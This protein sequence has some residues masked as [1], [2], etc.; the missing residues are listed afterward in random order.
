MKDAP[1]EDYLI[2]MQRLIAD[3]GLSDYN[4]VKIHMGMK[5]KDETYKYISP[6]TILD[7]A[8]RAYIDINY[9]GEVV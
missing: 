5:H 7:D 8:E 4:S 2:W 6:V 1:A 3:S 9:V